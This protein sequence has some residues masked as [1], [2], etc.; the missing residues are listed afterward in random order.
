MNLEL[1]CSGEQRSQNTRKK[2]DTINLSHE[3]LEEWE[4]KMDQVVK[5]A[6]C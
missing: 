4:G 2:Q 1:L 5:R 3:K 6:N